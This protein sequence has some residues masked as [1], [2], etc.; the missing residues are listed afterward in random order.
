MLATN[1]FSGCHAACRV[2][3]I[4]GE[5][6]DATGFCTCQAIQPLPKRN[7]LASEPLNP[8]FWSSIADECYLSRNPKIIS[9]SNS[10]KNS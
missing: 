7:D 6:D 8:T 1:G 2:R 10:G 4:P 3:V 9:L 5:A